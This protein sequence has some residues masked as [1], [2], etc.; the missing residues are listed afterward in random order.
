MTK[1]EAIAKTG[2]PEKNL[3]AMAMVFAEI[4]IRELIKNEP[5]ELLENLARAYKL[6]GDK[7]T[8]EIVNDHNGQL[9]L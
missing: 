7:M 5:C 1:E 2:I 9:R 4:R 3:M 6:I 8:E